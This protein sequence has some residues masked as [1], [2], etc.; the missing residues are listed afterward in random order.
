MN[1]VGL[2]EASL[3]AAQLNLEKIKAMNNPDHPMLKPAEMQV[4]ELQSRVN[5]LRAQM[6]GQGNTTATELKTY[7]QLTN[8]QTYADSNLLAA[9]QNYQQALNNA[10]ALQRYLAV[11][12]RPVSEVVPS[13]PNPPLFLFLAFAVGCALA[14][15]WT[16]AQGVYRSFRHA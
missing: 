5:D 6:S 4:Q 1:Q 12:A 14:G 13:Q 16:L 3:S 15:A 7:V 11:V 2:E 8:E 10:L 9:R